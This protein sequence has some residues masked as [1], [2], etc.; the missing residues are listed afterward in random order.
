MKDYHDSS[1]DRLSFRVDSCDCGFTARFLAG[2][3]AR[4]AA[5]GTHAPTYVPAPI[6][7]KPLTLVSE[8]DMAAFLAALSARARLVRP[9]P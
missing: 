5:A 8:A 3:E 2:Q 6:S 1:C 9:S 4:L 7:H